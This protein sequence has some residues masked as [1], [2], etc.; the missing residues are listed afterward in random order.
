MLYHLTTTTNIT[1]A[2]GLCSHWNERQCLDISVVCTLSKGLHLCVYRLHSIDVWLQ[3]LPT[4]FALNS[5][6]TFDSDSS[7]QKFVKTE[8]PDSYISDEQSDP[9]DTYAATPRRSSRKRNVTDLSKGNDQQQVL[10]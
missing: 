3:Q 6:T 1:S 8:E 4:P 10:V 7:Q 5:N 2:L 9:D